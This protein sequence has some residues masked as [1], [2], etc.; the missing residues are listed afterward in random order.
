MAARIS[1]LLK[2]PSCG[3]GLAR[4]TLSASTIE[5]LLTILL[6]YP[7]VCQA[8]DHRFLAFKYGKHY[9]PSR[10][11]RRESARIPVRLAL[12]FSGHQM[13]GEGTVV[14]LST[15]GCQVET[16][17]TVSVGALLYLQLFISSQE[18]PIEVAAV[19]RSVR[20]DRVGLKFLRVSREEKRLQ[21]FLRERAREE[22][23]RKRA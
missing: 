7:F 23:R 3:K 21:A 16:E 17:T 11:D 2:C 19:V 9:S 1:V 12:A 22:G 20:G 15:G 14:N 6:T 10:L 13:R 5:H 4:R 8:C 18:K